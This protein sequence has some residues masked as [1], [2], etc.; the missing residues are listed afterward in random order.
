VNV[1][2]V[3]QGVRD[4][5]WHL[6]DGPTNA[7][8]GVHLPS[9]H[10]RKLLRS[11]GCLSIGRC[12]PYKATTAP[13]PD[14]SDQPSKTAATTGVREVRVPGPIGTVLMALS[15]TAADQ[16]ERVTGRVE[17]NYQVRII[18]ILMRRKGPPQPY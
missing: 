3:E 16:A 11:P 6:V 9:D 14:P 4:E 10:M 8:L 17:H 18:R 2:E 5:W 7:R 12:S 15:D 1:E 13:A